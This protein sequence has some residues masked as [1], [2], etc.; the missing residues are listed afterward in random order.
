MNRASPSLLEFMQYYIDHCPEERGETY[1]LAK[2][3]GGMLIENCREVL[4]A[5][6]VYKDVQNPHAPKMKKA[7]VPP[8]VNSN[9]TSR[10]WPLEVK[11]QNSARN[12]KCKAISNEFTES[13]NN[14]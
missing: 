4:D 1:R 11:S 6:P 8:S 3:L 9:P 14:S 2:E 12:V 7:L 10:K 13:S 5:A